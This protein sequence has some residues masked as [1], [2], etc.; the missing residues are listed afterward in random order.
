MKEKIKE[1]RRMT[2]SGVIIQVK[3]SQNELMLTVSVKKP[4]DCMEGIR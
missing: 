3:K 4:N 2:N 1:L